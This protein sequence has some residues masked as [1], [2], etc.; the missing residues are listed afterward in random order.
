M[1]YIYKHNS[2]ISCCEATRLRSRLISVVYV[3]SL[4]CLRQTHLLRFQVSFD[5][6]ELVSVD[7]PKATFLEG[8]EG[9]EN[10]HD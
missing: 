5:L 7:V 8:S 10:F 3:F 1:Y 4:G 2:N 6:E 9:Y